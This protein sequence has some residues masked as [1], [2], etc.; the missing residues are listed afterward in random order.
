MSD[1]GNFIVITVT[2]Q[3]YPGI[4]SSFTRIL[5][6][7][8]VIIVDIEQVVIHKLILL[9]ILLDLKDCG[10]SEASLL[11]DLLLESKKLNLQLDFKIV[12]EDEQILGDKHFMYA[13]TCIGDIIHAEV[14]AQLSTVLSSDNINIERI[15]KLN[16]GKLNCVE[17]IVNT[18]QSI[19]IGDMTRKLMGISSEFG[20]DIAVQ[21]ENIFRRSKRLVVMDMDSTLIQ[22]EVIDE[23]AAAAGVGEEVSKI[24]SRAMDGELS[25]DESLHKRVGLLKGLPESVLE[26]VCK[27]IPFTLGAKKFVKILRKLGYKTVVI[28]GGFSFFTNR[29]QEELGLDHSFANTLEIV[30]GRL[31]GR[32]IGDVINAQSKADILCRIAENEGIALDQ[33][34]AIGDGANDLLMLDKAGL[35]I[36]FNAKKIVREKADYNISRKNLDS[37]I[38]LLG[39]SEKEKSLID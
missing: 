23:L 22:V 12:T 3:D 25:F 39:I 16:E 8:K 7:N 19:N 11:K 38:Y 6:K 1:S 4:V 15:T 32:V 13:I 24:T 14:L 26:D 21:K 37:I 28:S 2:G 18:S 10:E 9:S 5:S 35:G 27:Q 17:M 20:V 31:T 33:V 36:A 29:L 30:D 34:V